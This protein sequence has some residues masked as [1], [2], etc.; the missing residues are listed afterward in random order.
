MIAERI[1]KLGLKVAL[2]KTEAIYFPEAPEYSLFYAWQRGNMES[3]DLLLRGCNLVR[4]HPRSLLQ[5]KEAAERERENYSLAPPLRRRR[6]GERRRRYN[7]QFP[8]DR[9]QPAAGVGTP[10]SAMHQPLSLNGSSQVIIVTPVAPLMHGGLVGPA[11]IRRWA[12]R[13]RSLG[14]KAMLDPRLAP[15]SR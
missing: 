4:L 11:C 9:G 3:N 7:R 8:P 1:R 14:V 2:E 12:P 10:P 13:R 15:L 6:R 5:W